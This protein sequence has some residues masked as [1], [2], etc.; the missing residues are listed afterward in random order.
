MCAIFLTLASSF[1]TRKQKAERGDEEGAQQGD[2]DECREHDDLK[3]STRRIATT[4]DLVLDWW[5]EN[6]SNAL[7]RIRPWGRAP[8]CK[9]GNILVEPEDGESNESS[10][11]TPV[12]RKGAVSSICPFESNE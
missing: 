9:T 12:K 7:Y 1:M 4:R 10:Y 3:S 11:L 5:A 8:F 2:E 6:I